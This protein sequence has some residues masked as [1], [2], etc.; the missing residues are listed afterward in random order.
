MKANYS[1]KKEFKVE[2]DK[3]GETFEPNVHEEHLGEILSYGSVVRTYMQCP[4]TECNAQYNIGFVNDEVR[5]LLYENKEL[6]ST[7][8]ILPFTNQRMSRNKAKG[9]L[10]MKRI[11]TAWNQQLKAKEALGNGG[12]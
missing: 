1:R 6:S 2:C 4:N 5:K 9:E 12:A 3:C 11:E 10:L 7:S 8:L